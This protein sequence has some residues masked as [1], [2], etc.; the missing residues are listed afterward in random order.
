LISDEGARKV[1]AQA[2]AAL[3]VAETKSLSS[4]LSKQE[5][6]LINMNEGTQLRRAQPVPAP[7]AQPSRASRPQE[8]EEEAIRALS[9]EIMSAY[10]LCRPVAEMQ[11]RTERCNR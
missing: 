7:G 2:I 11:R 10:G 9:A 3:W 6:Q 8:P 4:A 1:T 5:N